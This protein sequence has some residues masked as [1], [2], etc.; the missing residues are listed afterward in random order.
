LRRAGQGRRT[1]DHKRALGSPV[2]RWS[3]VSVT[4]NR[5]HV[6]GA[7]VR[8]ARDWLVG[9]ALRW[10]QPPRVLL[11]RR[12]RCGV[13][14]GIRG[15]A[16]CQSVKRSDQGR[17][18][19]P[20]QIN[21]PSA[22]PRAGDSNR[23]PTQLPAVDPP[24][25]GPGGTRAASSLLSRERLPRDQARA[26]RPRE[27]LKP[28]STVCSGAGSATRRAATSSRWPETGAMSCSTASSSAGSVSCAGGDGAVPR[29]GL[30][31]TRT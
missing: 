20:R 5:S 11:T 22:T 12:R 14:P 10:K 23:A 6:A 3:S 15:G 1:E 28:P 8:P 27:S 25:G 24:H 31:A 26:R 30:S 9:D 2:R 17:H 16:P 18:D 4:R 29:V 13:A 7:R 21:R 19:A